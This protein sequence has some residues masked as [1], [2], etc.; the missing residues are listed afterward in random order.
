MKNLKI[1]TLRQKA[2]ARAERL[3]G[4]A[5]TYEGFIVSGGGSGLSITELSAYFTTK[6]ETAAQAVEAAQNYVTE[7]GTTDNYLTW[8]RGGTL[9]AFTVPYAVRCATVR[10]SASTAIDA[11]TI[12]DGNFLTVYSNLDPGSA[13]LPEMNAAW[14][15]TLIHIG[16]HHGGDAAQLFFSYGQPMKYRPTHTG[17][18]R[19]ILDSA[20]YQTVVDNTHVRRDGRVAMTGDLCMAGKK[21]YL[22]AARTVYIWYDS[23]NDCI[24]SNKTIASD[25]DIVALK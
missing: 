12:N 7:I 8:T 15:N 9:H 4:V 1:K 13:N 17:A 23:E 16:Q 22:D 19:V 18:W 21:I 14:V 10:T 20:S 11:N 6:E 3:R 5:S 2:T 25:Q 24:R